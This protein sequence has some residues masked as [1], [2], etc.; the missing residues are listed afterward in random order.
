MILNTI[1]RA[2]K[3]IAQGDSYEDKLQKSKRYVERLAENI[4]KE[5]QLL[6]HERINEVLGETRKLVS[7]VKAG[8]EDTVAL[9][10][11][12]SEGIMKLNDMGKGFQALLESS[13]LF[14][15]RLGQG[16]YLWNRS[17]DVILT[18]SQKH[19]CR[20]S[21]VE[22]PAFTYSRVPTPQRSSPPRPV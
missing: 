10:Q 22:Q 17:S 12:F 5:A 14:N 21:R 15:P 16:T 2:F 13:S 6:E 11:M 18:N 3:S 7:R 19:G 9:K 1:G 20:K 4:Q 8:E